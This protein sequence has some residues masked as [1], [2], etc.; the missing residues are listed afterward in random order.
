MTRSLMFG[1]NVAAAMRS[2]HVPRDYDALILDVATDHALTEGAL[3]LGACVLRRG[4]LTGG[5]VGRSRAR[6]GIG[7]Q[8]DVV[9]A[10]EGPASEDA[11]A[12]WPR[13][14]RGLVMLDEG[15]SGGLFLAFGGN[16]TGAVS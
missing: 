14:L 8:A 16:S 13:T 12:R 2:G 10:A 15:I 11:K 9:K 3:S 5:S 7:S 6:P 1:R 4:G